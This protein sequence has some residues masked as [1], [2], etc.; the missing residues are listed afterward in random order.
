M[1]RTRTVASCIS[2]LSVLWAPL[3]GGQL[4]AVP[5]KPLES[6]IGDTPRSV[7]KMLADAGEQPPTTHRLTTEE[8]RALAAAFG[9]LPPLHRR[10]L[11][12]RL[13]SISFLDGIPNTALTTP[14][15]PGG[16]G[17]RYHWTIRA[18][19]LHEN[20]SQWLTAKERTLFANGAR[21]SACRSRP[22]S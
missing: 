21:P 18:S 8:Q 3:A 14:V 4:P 15:N 13:A 10:V 7:L 12:E 20:V 22:A 19:V 6:R 17:T 16:A 1:I 5:V 11:A 2:V 9:A